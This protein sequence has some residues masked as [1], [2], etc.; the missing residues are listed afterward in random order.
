ML[1]FTIVANVRCT[2]FQQHFNRHRGDTPDIEANAISQPPQT[3]EAKTLRAPGP[4]CDGNWESC[5]G[6]TATP[7]RSLVNAPT[8]FFVFV[9]LSSAFYISVCY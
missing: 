2:F 1:S 3:A 4:N 6:A 8:A 9:A 7:M 5:M